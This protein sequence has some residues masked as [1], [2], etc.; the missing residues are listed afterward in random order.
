MSIRLC[1]HT[2]YTLTLLSACSTGIA[3]QVSPIRAAGLQRAST[4]VQ[5]RVRRAASLRMQAVDTEPSWPSD[6]TEPAWPSDS[7]GA[8]A[9]A[10]AT[11]TMNLYECPQC[12]AS[13]VLDDLSCSN[14]GAPIERKP[15]FVDLTPEATS[16]KVKDTSFAAETSRNPFFTVALSQ[17]G[18]QLSGQVLSRFS[19]GSL[20]ARL[21]LQA[22]I[23]SKT[24]SLNTRVQRRVL[25]R[26][27]SRG[28]T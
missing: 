15:S 10:V 3:F 26:E 19:A 16:K 1:L 22:R 6:E 24:R 20:R 4:C 13:I 12:K 5:S 8:V 28:G 2:A 27:S 23:V 9:S 14:C 25:E 11:P 21:L 18:A 17:I 7:S